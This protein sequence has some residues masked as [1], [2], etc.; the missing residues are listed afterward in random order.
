MSENYKWLPIT[1]YDPDTH[2]G[3]I[4]GWGKLPYANG[5]GLPDY[6]EAART[7]Q[8]HPDGEWLAFDEQGLTIWHP[9]HF[10]VIE[11]GPVEDE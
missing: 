2:T 10:M 6:Y 8:D 7:W 3:Q 1:D 9:T 11:D 4:I 5:P